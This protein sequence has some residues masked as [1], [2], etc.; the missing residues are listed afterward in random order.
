MLSNIIN[1]YYISYQHIM[2]PLFPL[3]EMSERVI[4]DLNG[5]KIGKNCSFLN[6]YFW[7]SKLNYI[8]LPFMTVAYYTSK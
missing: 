1:K 5:P 8:C 6:F 2:S 7:P 3:N 4:W